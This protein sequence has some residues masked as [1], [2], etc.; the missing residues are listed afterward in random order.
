MHYNFF[1]FD[2]LD[3]TST[4]QR[5]VG[6]SEK[7]QEYIQLIKQMDI[8]FHIIGYII[9]QDAKKVCLFPKILRC[10]SN[11]FVFAQIIE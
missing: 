8:L 7:V 9:V 4:D 11:L 1:L 10:Y 2:I 3:R 6:K 5:K